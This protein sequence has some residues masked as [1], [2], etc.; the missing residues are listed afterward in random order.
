MLQLQGER[1]QLIPVMLPAVAAAACFPAP[2]SMDCM[3]LAP[4]STA[5]AP[6]PLRD[7][8]KPLSK[9]LISAAYIKEEKQR[10]DQ[11]QLRQGTEMVKST[12]LLLV[13]CRWWCQ[14]G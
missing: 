14:P 4:S 12:Q 7:A 3:G 1:Q 8:E 10:A 2:R 9:A 6:L 13:C 5:S 11:L